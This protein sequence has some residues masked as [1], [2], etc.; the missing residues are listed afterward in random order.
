[1]IRIGKEVTF[2]LVNLSTQL[3]RI[4]AKAMCKNMIVIEACP[5]STNILLSKVLPEI[6][7]EISLKMIKKETG[8]KI[9]IN[10][11]E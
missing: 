6:K 5:I 10:G 8:T 9:F 7:M 11:S 4:E 1:M 3:I 2:T